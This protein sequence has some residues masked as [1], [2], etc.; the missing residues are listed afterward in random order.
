MALALS[1]QL[2]RVFAIDLRS[3]AAFRIAIGVLLLVD[4]GMRWE[5]WREFYTEAGPYPAAAARADLVSTWSLY[6]VTPSSG[7]AAV[8]LV[9]QAVAGGALT[10]GWQTRLATILSWLLLVSLH[11]RN[12]LV[13]NGGDIE[14]RLLLFWAMWLPLGRC[15]SIDAKLHRREHPRDIVVSAASAALLLQVALIYVTSAL[16]KTDPVWWKT[17]EAIGQTLRLESYVLPLGEQLRSWPGL[18]RIATFATLALELFGPLL[19]LL[20]SSRNRLRFA[21]AVMFIGFHLFLALTLRL[22]IFPWVGMAGWI[23]F[24]PGW[25]WKA[26]PSPVEQLVRSCLYSTRWAWAV[27]AAV[28]GLFLLAFFSA[29]RPWFPGLLPPYLT[30][31]TRALRVAQRWELFAP[32][33]IQR[34]GWCVVVGFHGGGAEVDL[35]TGREPVWIEPRPLHCWYKNERWRRYYSRL[36]EQRTPWR[37]QYFTRWVH[38]EFRRAHRQFPTIEQISVFGVFVFTKD[39]SQVTQEELYVW[40]EELADAPILPPKLEYPARL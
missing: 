8:L 27:N 12:E 37:L 16:L 32:R 19:T 25:I 17:G 10:V 4:V 6:L 23:P 21:V 20:P 15:W 28:A 24:L 38:E 29:L 18:L 36:R 2:E 26:R 30:T 7:W 13:L 34:E 40:P 39:R 22:G 31:V 9:L 1:S 33:P 3:L 35:L 5:D 14:L 11:A